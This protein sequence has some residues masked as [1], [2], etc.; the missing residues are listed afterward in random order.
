MRPG[1]LNA[2]GEEANPAAS[3]ESRTVCWSDVD[4]G[5]G[6]GSTRWTR[7]SERRE[8]SRGA[9]RKAGFMQIDGF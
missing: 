4:R 7:E 5:R 9:T 6:R 8:V 3:G 1:A 2:A